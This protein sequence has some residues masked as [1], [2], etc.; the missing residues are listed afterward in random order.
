MTFEHNQGLTYT[1][2][3]LRFWATVV[4]LLPPTA[5]ISAVAI[6]GNVAIGQQMAAGD[7]QV[8]AL[9]GVAGLIFSI[10]VGGLPALIYMF[11]PQ[12]LAAIFIL[13]YFPLGIL[14]ICAANVESVP[15][16][17]AIQTTAA[18][19]EATPS[20]E[21]WLPSL[22]AGM[23][24]PRNRQTIERE[25][26]K[27][28]S[29][30]TRDVWYDSDACRETADYR[31]CGRVAALRAELNRV[32]SSETSHPAG[33]TQSSASVTS[34]PS[35]DA[36]PILSS[37]AWFVLYL[38]SMVSPAL[39]TAGFLETHRSKPEFASAADATAPQNF[40]Q[41]D[42]R[43]MDGDPIEG[44]FTA[45]FAHGITAWVEENVSLDHSAS[46]DVVDAHQHYTSWCA[47]GGV[48]PV[49][50]TEFMKVLGG[51]LIELGG[52]QRGVMIDAKTGQCIG[53]RLGGA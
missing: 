4:V 30:V 31:E 50:T 24:A 18:R 37:T 51:R 9:F 7:F 3:Q 34:T 6:C 12:R 38:L 1:H 8:S 23:G 5:L 28:E 15:R 42:H 41:F 48:A 20:S 22:F 21:G 19:V 16:T 32:I 53:V 14:Q 52:A 33:H 46:F 45:Q 39:C 17:A 36:A 27:A 11:W 13:A 2:S 26:S 29:A 10:L 44:A 35:N 25:I 43:V 47:F 40:V 49:D